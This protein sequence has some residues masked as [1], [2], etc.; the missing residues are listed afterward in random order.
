L[1]ALLNNDESRGKFMISIYDDHFP[2]ADAGAY[3]GGGG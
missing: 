1:F 2:R 3:A